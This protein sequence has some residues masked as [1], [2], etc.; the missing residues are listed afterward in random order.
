MA[1][2]NKRTKVSKRTVTGATA[3]TPIINLSPKLVKGLSAVARKAGFKG[4]FGWQE[5]AIKNLNATCGL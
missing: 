2:K 1:M 3:A 5:Y 4:K